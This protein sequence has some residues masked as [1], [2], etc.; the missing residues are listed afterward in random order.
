MCRLLHAYRI[1]DQPCQRLTQFIL[2]R[3]PWRSMSRR[4]R[5]RLYIIAEFFLN[6]L[7]LSHPMLRAKLEQYNQD[8]LSQQRPLPLLLSP[9]LSANP[10]TSLTQRR[11]VAH[12]SGKARPLPYPHSHGRLTLNVR[13]SCA[14]TRFLI[15]ARGR[16]RFL[17]T[18]TSAGP[19][20]RLTKKSRRSAQRRPG[21]NA[22][23]NR[24]PSTWPSRASRAP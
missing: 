11:G 21:T 10:Q 18:T 24:R 2:P 4:T 20:N 15:G 16:N 12:R 13:R 14:S 3:R 19:H 9:R 6:D 8:P 17:P 7:P 5:S 1:G 23:Q 22:E